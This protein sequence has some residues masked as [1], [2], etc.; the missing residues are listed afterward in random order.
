MTCSARSSRA[1]AL[2][3]VAL[4]VHGAAFGQDGGR[5]AAAQPEEDPKA[6]FAEAQKSYQLGRFQ[7]AIP[8]YERVFEL[9]NHPSLL[10]NLA[11]CHRQLSN[12]ERAA[13]FYDRYLATAKPPIPNEQLARELL[14]EMTKKRDATRK[15][16]EQQAADKAAADER[17]RQ[18]ADGRRLSQTGP[19]A[20]P[21]VQQWWFW[22]AIGGAAVAAGT[23]TA[24]A[25]AT[26][27][28]PP[29]T[30]SLGTIQF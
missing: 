28:P 29:P 14:A 16:A 8:R 1:A 21:V 9:T 23:I 27:R 3:L 6:V 19:E 13:F 30:T 4:L 5:A 18:E 10:F 25:V 11:Q 12:F 2:F 7:E 15:L 24:V 22:V 20:K 17:A 26:S